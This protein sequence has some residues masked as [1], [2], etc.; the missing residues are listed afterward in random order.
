MTAQ[1]REGIRKALH[2]CQIGMS[3]DSEGEGVSTEPTCFVRVSLHPPPR[4]TASANMDLWLKQ[5]ELRTGIPA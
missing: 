3:S 4:Y 2:W 1:T 5:F